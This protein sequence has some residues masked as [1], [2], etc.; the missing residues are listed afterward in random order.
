[1]KQKEKKEK[2]T[3]A[4]EIM[5]YLAQHDKAN[6]WELS[7]TLKKSYGNTHLTI[8]NLEKKKLI[9]SI[10][11][12]KTA[13][14]PNIEVE[15][16]AITKFGILALLYQLNGEELERVIDKIADRHKEWSLIFAKWLLFKNDG[17]RDYILSTLKNAVDVSFDVTG[18]V[19]F[20]DRQPSKL[21]IA[22]LF[23]KTENFLVK[24]I[25]RIV[26][27]KPIAEKNEQFLKLYKQDSVLNKF[28]SVQID[29]NLK[30]MFVQLSVV[31][32]I[33]DWWMSQRMETGKEETK[34]QKKE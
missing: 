25:E 5:I 23:Q 9:K 17:L 4:K 14:N 22:L 8:S 30:A 7:N 27:M 18:E 21:E 3:T 11:K 32:S 2:G 10:A 6:R 26:L 15:S 24:N 1:M 34:I 16:Y 13:R 20:A 33:K 19:M 31:K 12:K 29:E 28:V